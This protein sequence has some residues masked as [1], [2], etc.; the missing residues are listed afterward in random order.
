MK[1]HKHAEV[2]K[3]WADGSQIETQVCRIDASIPGSTRIT[4]P[5]WVPFDGKWLNDGVYRVK[6]E[7][8]YPETSMTPYICLVAAKNSDA[9]S[10][11]CTDAHLIAIANAALR[12]A[13]DAGQVVTKDEH[14]S[15]L[16]RLGDHLCGIAIAPDAV[17]DMAIAEA[18][19]N[20]CAATMGGACRSTFKRIDLATIIAT[21]K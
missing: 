10:M 11:D 17:R 8:A 3:A 2:I 16:A 9:R 7:K 14:E 19:R 15:A 1:P 6:P 20:E 5:Y 13:I 21:I 4:A 12:H 18:V